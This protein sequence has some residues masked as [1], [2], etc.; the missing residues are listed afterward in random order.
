MKDLGDIP[1]EID[2]SSE[3]KLTNQVVQGFRSAIDHGFYRAGD[4]LPTIRALAKTLGVSEMVVRAA[5]RQLAADGDIV[6]RT[7]LGSV[8]TPARG[9]AW[10]G[11]VLAVMTD[12]DF[13]PMM[14][15][16]F[17]RLRERF[18]EHGYSFVQTMA[19]CD[20]DHHRS[21]ESL[22]LH[23]RHGVDF[24]VL[25]YGCE[26]IERHLSEVGIP[27]CV[28][29]DSTGDYMPK[30]CVGRVGT[31]LRN[32]V[33]D[34][35]RD[36]RL[37]GV[38]T[39]EIVT[40]HAGTRFSTGVSEGLTAA[41]VSVK[42]L[43]WEPS[44]RVARRFES[45][46][47]RGF[48]LAQQVARRKRKLPD[49]FFV[50]DDFVGSG[51]VHGLSAAGVR[52]PEDVGVVSYANGGCGPFFDRPVTVIEHDAF[53]SGDLIADR[54]LKYLRLRHPFPNEKYALVYRRGK[55]FGELQKGARR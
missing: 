54:I 44:Y 10:R 39:V 14:A 31:S 24:I 38:R 15:V 6:G 48:A 11:R 25:M 55:T 45:A 35:V 49:V 16:H 43:P 12:Y 2:F 29:G 20:R 3:E 5:Y 51:F 21:Y 34:F 37:C 40:T 30:G 28:V 7:R 46:F 27:F 19:L 52:M 50:A 42:T 18:E 23:L 33:D 9:K 53:V 13:N 8:V 32:A 26:D 4:R 1:F 41:G 36:C 17:S 47:E 22:E